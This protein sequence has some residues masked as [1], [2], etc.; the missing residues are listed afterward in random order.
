MNI[1]IF[2]DGNINWYN[3]FGRHFGNNEHVILFDLELYF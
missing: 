3:F 2:A 1:F